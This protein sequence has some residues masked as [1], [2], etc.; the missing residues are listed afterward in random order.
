MLNADEA[1]S[2]TARSPNEYNEPRYHEAISQ[3]QYI[4]SLVAEQAR[5]GRSHAEY[6]FSGDTEIAILI[7]TMLHDMNYKCI[8]NCKER[9]I[10]I[11]W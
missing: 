9:K 1:R 2:L 6:A 4:D 7:I 3:F 8:Y 10:V 5:R 11:T